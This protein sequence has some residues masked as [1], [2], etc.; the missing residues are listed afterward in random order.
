MNNSRSR[1][2][3]MAIVAGLGI[4]ASSVALAHV[5][6]VAI[7]FADERNIGAIG[8]ALVFFDRCAHR[9][10]IEVEA[11]DRECRVEVDREAEH[12]KQQNRDSLKPDFA[13]F[14]MRLPRIS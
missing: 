3:S 7:Y 10:P 13:P 2:L 4:G 5:D 6:G 1:W 8:E 14:Q 9:S 11:F 12:G